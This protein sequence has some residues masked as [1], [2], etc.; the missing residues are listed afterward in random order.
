MR[1]ES[2]K[3]TTG[4]RA[5]VINAPH[6]IDLSSIQRDSV[7]VQLPDVY[8]AVSITTIEASVADSEIV[9]I[10]PTES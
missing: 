3:I 1:A 9:E 4:K 8:D 7:V 5:R 6:R 10:L 2:S